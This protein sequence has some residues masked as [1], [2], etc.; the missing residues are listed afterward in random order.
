MATV[1]DYFSDCH[2]SVYNKHDHLTEAFYSTEYL[3]PTTL[4]Y[5]LILL[6]VLFFSLHY[7]SQCATIPLVWFYCC[8]FN[9]AP[10]FFSSS[11]H[12]L[13]PQRLSVLDVIS[14]SSS[15]FWYLPAQTLSCGGTAGPAHTAPLRSSS[16]DPD[17]CLALLCYENGKLIYTSHHSELIN[18]C[19]RISCPNP[20]DFCLDQSHILLSIFKL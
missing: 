5:P 13:Q 12:P 7:S 20:G 4:M 14:V 16:S 8:Y 10:E 3:W 15:D 1:T 2:I 9:K 18:K 17:G 11:G 19:T 6:I